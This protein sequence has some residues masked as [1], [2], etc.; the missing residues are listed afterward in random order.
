MKRVLLS[1]LSIFTLAATLN[2]A[3]SQSSSAEVKF[4]HTTQRFI[5]SDSALDRKKYFNLHSVA[6]GDPDMS[7]F[8][9][10]YDVNIGR[11]YVVTGHTT[12][13]HGEMDTKA[14]MS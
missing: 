2:A 13:L 8:F 10:K 4:D 9:K 5:G 14:A 3:P 11:N 12:Y 1:A 7:A 6:D